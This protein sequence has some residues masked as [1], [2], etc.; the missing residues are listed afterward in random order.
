[1]NRVRGAVI[2][3]AMALAASLSARGSPVSEVQTLDGAG[4]YVD[5]D[6][7]WCTITGEWTDG[8]GRWKLTLDGEDRMTLCL[9]GKTAAES[10][11]SFRYLRP[12]PSQETEFTA[13]SPQLAGTGG[14]IVSLVHRAG[15]KGGT[16]TL[17]LVGP[18]GSGEAVTLQKIENRGTGG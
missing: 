14:E 6:A 13:A 5:N 4:T 10:A 2:L 3:M 15:E 1:M 16:L 9:D 18:D 12:E 7:L 8:S 17:E 11:L